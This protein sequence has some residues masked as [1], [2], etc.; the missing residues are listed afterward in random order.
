[1]PA[2]KSVQR[3]LSLIENDKSKILGLSVGP[4]T[5]VQPGTY[6]PR[7]GKAVFS[8]FRCSSKARLTNNLEAQSAP[9]L[10]FDIPDPSKTYMVVGLDI[11]APFP[12][13]D[14]LGPILHWIQPGLCTKD[15][16][17]KATEPFVANYIGPAP[18]P[19]S[20]PHRYIFFLYEQPAGFDGKKYAPP[21][22]ENLSNW[23]RVRFSLDAWEKKTQLG[24]LLAVNYFCSN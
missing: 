12:S 7:A 24:K 13:F 4:H 22:G 14:V 5:N 8:L 20:S 3:A 2:N 6:I 17:L 18:P 19:G 1:M 21:N 16:Q 23:H 9:Q 10:A 11:D 15:S